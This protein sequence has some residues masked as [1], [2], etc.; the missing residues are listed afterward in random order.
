MG[1][2][3][4]GMQV[5]HLLTVVRAHEDRVVCSGIFETADKKATHSLL[6]PVIFHS[7]IEAKGP[8]KEG[9]ALLRY[10][11]GTHEHRPKT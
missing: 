10:D 3:R 1:N 2:N 8:I 7:A 11:D 9:D 6:H 4:I 5:T